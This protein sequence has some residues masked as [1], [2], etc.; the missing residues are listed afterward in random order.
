MD[1]EYLA[2]SGNLYRDRSCS[3]TRTY[4]VSN[5]AFYHD[6]KLRQVA[7]GY[8][9]PLDGLSINNFLD[10]DALSRIAGTTANRLWGEF[11]KFDTVIV[12]FIGIWLIIKIVADTIIHGYTLHSVYGWS[13]HLLGAIFASVT[14]LL[15]SL[16]G[17]RRSSRRWHATHPNHDPN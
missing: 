12:G 16:G 2:S 5:W 15:M 9:V 8:R 7:A 3:I 11:L 17:K 6:E 1:T 10:E 14:S 13:I 4:H